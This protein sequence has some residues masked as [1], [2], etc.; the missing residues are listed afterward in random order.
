VAP[1]FV[2]FEGWGF[3]LLTAFAEVPTLA[4]NARMGHL[5]QVEGVGILKAISM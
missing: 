4:K 2:I 1:P 5:S 3:V